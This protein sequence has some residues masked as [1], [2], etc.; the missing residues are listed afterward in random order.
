[1]HVPGYPRESGGG[2]VGAALPEYLA[3]APTGSGTSDST[4]RV[5]SGGGDVANMEARGDNFVLSY[6]LL[7]VLSTFK[8]TSAEAKLK[9]RLKGYLYASKLKKKTLP[10]IA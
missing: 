2:G 1:M 7:A 5:Q 3:A 10:G 4:S 9:S 6:N 8:L